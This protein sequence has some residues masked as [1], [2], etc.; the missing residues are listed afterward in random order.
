MPKLLPEVFVSH[1]NIAPYVSKEVKKGKLRKLGSLVY[2]TNLQE[3][4]EVLVRRHVW[5]LV[6]ELFPGAL[7]VDRT[8]LEHRPAADGSVFIISNKKRPVILPGIAIYPRKGPVPLPE[9][10]P[11]MEGL[12]LACPAR[13]YLENLTQRRARKGAIPRTLSREELEEKLETF[14]QTAGPEALQKLRQDASQIAPMLHLKAEF[15]ILD[16]LIGTLLGTRKSSVTS[17]LALARVQGHPYDAKRLGLFQKLYEVLANAPSASRTISHSGTAL[18]F[19]EAYFSNFIEG[20]EFEVEEAAHIIFEGKIP[21]D[22]P[23]DAHDILG[24]YKMTSDPQE[25]KKRPHNA[26]ELILLLKNR[27]ACL[28]RSRPEMRPGEFKTLPNRA[29]LTFFVA[30]ELVEGTL[31]Q[32]FKWLQAL[33]TPF[34]K[35]V[36]MMFLISEVHPFVDGNGR[37]ARIMM[38]SELVAAGQARIIIPTI[39][40]NNYLSALKNLSHNQHAEPLIRVL[41]FAQHYTS[42]IDWNSFKNAQQMLKETHAFD[43]PNTADLVGIQLKFPESF[44]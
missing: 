36:Y 31:K 7:V 35:A 18:P 32:G 34:Q 21:T 15:K 10:K 42:L 11:F 22:R 17:P 3:P 43:D 20:T 38:N 8:A 39:F 1:A 9:D 2:T 23:Q 33:E 40:R 44:R 28:M 27:H 6:G 37:C 26:D 5:M 19:F 16:G 12:Y 30:P 13:A 41:D 4:S 14:L 24:T 29:G 25:M